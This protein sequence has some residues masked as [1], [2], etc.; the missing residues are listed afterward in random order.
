SSILSNPHFRL[1]AV[2][3]V[4]SKISYANPNSSI[5]FAL[6][7]QVLLLAHRASPIAAATP[8]AGA[9]RIAN[10]FIASAMSRWFL[11]IMYSSDSGNLVWSINF[12]PSFSQAIVVRYFPSLGLA[13]ID[14]L[15]FYSLFISTSIKDTINIFMTMHSLNRM[16]FK[17]SPI[18]QNPRRKL[19]VSSQEINLN[20]TDDSN[21]RENTIF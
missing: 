21:R 14:K 20:I 6:L 11:Q 1:M 18:L 5:I 15:H 9:P 4:L 10:F 19:I 13:I 12:T 7:L 3:L 16:I 17:I 8:I 2:G